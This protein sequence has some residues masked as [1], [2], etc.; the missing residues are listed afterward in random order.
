MTIDLQFIHSTI[1][2]EWSEKMYSY[3]QEDLYVLQMT[4]I[5][6]LKEHLAL[7]RTQLEPKFGNVSSGIS[8]TFLQW[9]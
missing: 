2:F 3:V 8:G 4:P 9:Q 1:S 7:A 5:S 6:P